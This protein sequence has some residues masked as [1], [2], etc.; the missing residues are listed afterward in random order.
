MT[1]KAAVVPTNVRAMS[2]GRNF[3]V[4]FEA[5]VRD[6]AGLSRAAI[7]SGWKGM[8]ALLAVMFAAMAPLSSYLL[9]PAREI[10]LA[11]SAAPASISS[12]AT[13]MVLTARGYTPAAKGDNGFTCLVDRAWDQPFD[14]EPF[15]S[16]HMMA[17]TCFNREASQTVLPY[18]YKRTQ[19]VL[20]GATTTKELSARMSA[21]IA[22]GTLPA[23]APGA[24]SYMMSKH[25][26]LGA[27]GTA[28]FPHV[29][30][31]AP[32]AD[33][34]NAGADWGA[35]LARSPIVYDSQHR[36]TPEPWALFF[37]PVSHWSDGSPAPPYTG[38]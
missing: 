11:R 25:Q 3:G 9:S 10:A 1:P 23:V 21:A 33:G 8:N 34:T 35:D 29:M 16:P 12:H 5:P 18:L 30:F 2:T 22:G 27:Q 31:Y 37:I 4:W 28:W 38:M 26:M 15:W 32:K 17:P 36:L 24:M 7:V 14:M 6:G 13:I 19:L 20:A